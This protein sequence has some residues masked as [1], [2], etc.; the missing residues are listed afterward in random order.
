MPNNPYPTTVL[1]QYTSSR[2][3]PAQR[4]HPAHPAHPAHRSTRST[5]SRASRGRPAQRPHPAHPAH[6]AHHVDQLTSLTRSAGAATSPGSAGSPGSASSPGSRGRPAQRPHP[7]RPAHQAR[8]AHPVHEVGR[9]SDL[10]RL[11]RLGRLTWLTRSTRS[12]SSPA[13]QVD[14]PSVLNPARPALV[15]R[16]SLNLV[17][18]ARLARHRPAQLCQSPPMPYRR[19]GASRPPRPGRGLAHVAP[20]HDGCEAH[21]G[22]GCSDGWPVTGVLEASL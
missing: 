13:H 2:G 14:H 4:P 21:A 10:T 7:A 3:R 9:R 8:P 12:T 22:Q 15:L 19:C 20:L 5:S 18:L 6:P 11:G 17:P 16:L 1:A